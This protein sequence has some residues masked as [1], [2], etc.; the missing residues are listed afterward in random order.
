MEVMTV[1]READGLRSNDVDS[2]SYRSE[3]GP[4]SS[5][6]SSLLSDPSIVEFIVIRTEL[7]KSLCDGFQTA[8]FA[9]AGRS[10]KHGA[11]ER[12]CREI[13]GYA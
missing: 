13:R 11:D 2:V 6:S 12:K 5:N 9:D 8:K 4:S 7:R 10:S 1:A 3:I